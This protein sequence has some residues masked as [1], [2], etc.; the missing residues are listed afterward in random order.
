MKKSSISTDTVVFLLVGGLTIIA[1][2]LIAIFAVKEQEQSKGSKE[3]VNYSKQDKAL[4]QIKVSDLFADLGKMEIKDEKTATFLL[5]NAGTKPLQ[6]FNISSSCNCTF[7]KV[8][9]EGVTSPEFNMHS[10]SPW[11]GTIEPGKEA[12]LSVIYRPSLMP[13][14]GPVTRQ[15][16]VRTNDPENGQLTFTVKAL[17]E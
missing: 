11:V 8:T 5:K 7:G 16:L 1:L 4:P 15:V 14:K 12:L 9:I 13:V 17:V 3:I 10:K 2:V 6:L